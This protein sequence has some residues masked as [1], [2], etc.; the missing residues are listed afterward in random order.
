MVYTYQLPLVTYPKSLSLRF[1]L[2]NCNINII[3]NHNLMKKTL[4]KLL[5]FINLG[6]VF[7]FWY[8]GSASFI[9]EGTFAGI[10][11]ALGRITGLLAEFFILL[12]LVLIAR[13]RWIEKQ[14]GHDEFTALHRTVGTYLILLM[15]AHPILLS[16][17]WGAMT[18]STYWSQFLSFVTDW[19]DV[20]NALIGLIIFGIATTLSLTMFK[21]KLKYE[22]W[23]FTHLFIYIAIA[24]AFSH[25]TNTGDM[26]RGA[27]LYYWLTI[28][29]VVFGLMLLFRFLRPFFLFF[30]HRFKISKIEAESPDVWSVYVEG[31]NLHK[32]NFEAGQFAIINFLK[33]GMWSSHPFSFSSA[34]NGQYVRFTIK[35]LGDFTSRIKEL[36]I[37]TKV[38]IDGPLGTFTE[39]K[40]KTNRFLFIAGGVGITPITGM[41]DSLTK[42]GIRDIVLLYCVRT[43]AQIPFQKILDSLPIKTFYL[44]SDGVVNEG[45]CFISGRIDGDKIKKF[46]P[47]FLERDV[48]FCGP[49]VMNGP[50]LGTLSKMGVPKDR[51]HFERFGF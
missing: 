50:V 37:G 36:P 43:A 23:H 24:L 31:R 38:I 45:G 13:I 5:L 7:Y 12:Q 32:F 11:I 30:R 44:I 29:F 35:A 20:L 3:I 21:K 17:G 47:D 10:L 25:Q 9:K 39:S 1:Y 34:P 15:I 18:E 41:I 42:K 2:K 19:R 49:P 51:I 16:M 27:A 4:L 26:A 22:R 46:A 28:N 33:K 8:Q 6:V 14:F 48:F 40:S